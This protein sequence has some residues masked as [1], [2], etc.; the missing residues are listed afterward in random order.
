MALVAEIDI[1]FHQPQPLVLRP[2]HIAFARTVRPGGDTVVLQMRQTAIPQRARGAHIRLAGIEP[3]HLQYQPDSGSSNNGSPNDC[4]NLS[5]ASSG[6]A[7]SATS[8]RR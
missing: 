8:V 4:G 5:F 7:T 6:E 1:A 3:G 2:G